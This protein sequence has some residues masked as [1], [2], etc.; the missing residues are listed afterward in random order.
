[1]KE[2]QKKSPT[3]NFPLGVF[4]CSVPPPSPPAVGW[5]VI[6]GSYQFPPSVILFFFWTQ[7]RKE[8]VIH[9]II[10]MCKLE[11]L[12]V[13]MAEG[14]ML[15]AAKENCAFHFFVFVIFPLSLPFCYWSDGLLRVLYSFYLPAIKTGQSGRWNWWRGNTYIFFGGVSDYSRTWVLNTHGRR[16]DGCEVV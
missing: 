8:R 9:V 16:P 12:F 2:K 11:L 5:L 10:R 1:M 13:V 15:R 6:I 7:K 14:Y 3:G 4:S